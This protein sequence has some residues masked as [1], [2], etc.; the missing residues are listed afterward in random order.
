LSRG[1]QFAS[2]QELSGE[3]NPASRPEFTF[4]IRSA[5]ALGYR[6]ESTIV[7]LSREPQRQETLAIWRHRE[8]KGLVSTQLPLSESEALDEPEEVQP[9]NLVRGFQPGARVRLAKA[10]RC[11]VL[12]KCELERNMIFYQATKATAKRSDCRIP[13]SWSCRKEREAGSVSAA[14]QLWL[15]RKSNVQFAA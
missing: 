1:Y 4:T 7:I 2:W 12:D 8:N 3:E 13:I 11:F 14:G 15:K 5:A 9:R 10:G 6:R